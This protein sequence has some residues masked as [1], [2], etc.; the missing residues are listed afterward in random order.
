VAISLFLAVAR[1]SD[2]GLGIAVLDDP[3]QSLDSAHKRSL[4]EVLRDFA[5]ERQIL[6]ATEDLELIDLLK[7][8]TPNQVIN[9]VHKPHQGT[10]AQT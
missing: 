7:A 3:S 2:S 10:V 4:A 1:S 8:N 6:I 9:L 5:R